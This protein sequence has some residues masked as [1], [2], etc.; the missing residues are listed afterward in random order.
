MMFSLSVSRQF[1]SDTTG[2]PR[3]NFSKAGKI[4][5]LKLMLG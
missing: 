1:K 4:I 3:R 5:Y 2:K